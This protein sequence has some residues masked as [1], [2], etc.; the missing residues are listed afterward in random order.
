MRWAAEACARPAL[1]DCTEPFHLVPF[2][3]RR[4]RQQVQRERSCC[5]SVVRQ[6]EASRGAFV[7]AAPR[8][9]TAGREQKGP[10]WS[11][12]GA[13]LTERRRTGRLANKASAAERL[14]EMISLLF[15]AR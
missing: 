9:I 13:C 8:K 3:T 10:P 1:C 4:M 12:S 7:P 15:N 2:C 14:R 6:S 11:R 5:L